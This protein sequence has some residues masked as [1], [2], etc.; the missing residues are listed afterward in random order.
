MAFG[1]LA[2]DLISRAF[3]LKTELNACLHLL[4]MDANHS[5][6]WNMINQ[7]E[8]FLVN[9]ALAISRATS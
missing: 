8:R 1:S 9:A 4:Y 6:R 5:L 3:Q 2:F 7:I